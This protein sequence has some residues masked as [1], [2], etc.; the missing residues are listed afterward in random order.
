MIG[1]KREATVKYLR[2]LAAFIESKQVDVTELS[3]SS[4]SSASK[5]IDRG[6][7][8]EMEIAFQI[9]I[10]ADIYEDLM[11]LSKK[12]GDVHLVD[13]ADNQLPPSGGFYS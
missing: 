6:E 7:S 10:R 8:V 11:E 12:A 5:T 9:G 13:R 4:H 3:V 1:R 2:E